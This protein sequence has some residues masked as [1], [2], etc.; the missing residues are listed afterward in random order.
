MKILLRILN[1]LNNEGLPGLASRLIVRMWHFYLA[2]SKK[3]GLSTVKSRY[4]PLFLANYGDLTFNA[5][6]TGA[7]GKFY[8][9]EIKKIDRPFIFLDIGA[10]QG[11]YSICAAQNPNSQ[12]VF[13]FEPVEQIVRLLRGN[14]MANKLSGRVSIID[15]AIS[16]VVGE[17][18]IRVFENHSG[19]ATISIKNVEG[20]A[21]HV[22]KLTIN[23]INHEYLN[24][25]I[26]ADG[27]GL[28]IKID[29]E[30]HEL[31]VIREILG[32]KFS[33]RIFH[34]FYE[35]DTNWNDPEEIRALLA[36]HGFT[37]TQIG[38]GSHYDVLARRDRAH[39]HENAA[40]VS[41]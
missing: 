3:L 16:D 10:N 5:Y 26:G 24:S 18:D 34:I 20:V 31:I 32:T 38:Y 25:I 17:V 22:K 37:I 9:N 6:I 39:A 28:A 27:P 8:W 15:A 40:A 21:H 11:L 14:V 41:S 19:K 1:V 13:A 30:G 7:Y 2:A 12:E 35:V 36:E 29:V 23:T 4:G 33:D